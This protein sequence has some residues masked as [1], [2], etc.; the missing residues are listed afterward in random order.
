[1]PQTDHVSVLSAIKGRSN[2]VP[3]AFQQD[4]AR[5]RSDAPNTAGN[6]SPYRCSF[7]VCG[8]AR[9]AV[10]RNGW[11]DGRVGSKDRCRAVSRSTGYTEKERRSTRAADSKSEREQQTSRR[12]DRS[13]D[14]CEARCN[15]REHRDERM[16]ETSACHETTI[17][18]QAV[19]S[20]ANASGWTHV[21]EQG[22]GAAGR[23]WM[24]T[25]YGHSGQ[26]AL[27]TNRAQCALTHYEQKEYGYP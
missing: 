7:R 9:N 15:E 18:E 17:S 21:W 6:K 16:Q 25:S 13:E 14:L 27:G 5:G 11:G 24:A 3:P 12:R 19:R 23:D 26:T 22:I 1:M 8:V 4:E 20:T 10:A 2:G